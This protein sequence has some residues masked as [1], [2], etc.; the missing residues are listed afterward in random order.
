[1]P[2]LASDGSELAAPEEGEAVVSTLDSILVMKQ[3]SHVRFVGFTFESARG[4][5]VAVKPTWGQSTLLM[6]KE[7]DDEQTQHA[8]QPPQFPP[9]NAAAGQQPD[10]AASA[11]RDVH[12]LNCT[13]VGAGSSGVTFAGGINSTISGT[14]VGYTGC[15]GLS[16]TGP[17]V[18]GERQSWVDGE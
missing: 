17:Y 4:D 7:F 16:V 12:V 3:V 1:V 8:T 2:P 11:W 6:E 9:D 5:A 18:S 10:P 13:V 15:K 14:E